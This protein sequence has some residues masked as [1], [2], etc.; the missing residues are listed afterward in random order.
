MTW[1]L[2]PGF[3]TMARTG[4]DAL[5]VRGPVVEIWPMLEEDISEDEIVIRLAQRYSVSE[6]TIRHDVL[7]VLERLVREGFVDE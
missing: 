4:R 7:P 2:V 5:T 1:R 6:S 3:L